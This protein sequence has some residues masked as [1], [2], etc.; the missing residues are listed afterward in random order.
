M[1]ETLHNLTANLLPWW[2]PILVIGVFIGIVLVIFALVTIAQGKHSPHG[3][4]G[5]IKKGLL[6]FFVGI[7]L[8]NILA[9]INVLTYSML[10]TDGP[11]TL[12]YAPDAEVSGVYAAFA[13]TVFAIVGAANL[14]RGLL[15][16]RHVAEDPNM[17]ASGLTHTFGSIALLNA[18][19]VVAVF[20]RSAGS[21]FERMVQTLSGI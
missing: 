7:A 17:L 5:A 9:T 6:S 18:T 10:Q 3:L 15:K 21:D 4:G 16:L 11:D 2:R 13:V 12:S 1:D 20:A 8:I 19:T 14:I